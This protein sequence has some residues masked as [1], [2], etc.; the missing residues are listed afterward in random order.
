MK[1]ML[2]FVGMCC[3]GAALVFGDI[4]GVQ[5]TEK[6]M[7]L[8]KPR[9]MRSALFKLVKKIEGDTD[10]LLSMEAKISSRAESFLVENGLGTGDGRLPVSGVG[11]VNELLPV[12]FMET[13]VLMNGSK[14]N[15]DLIQVL[16]SFCYYI[17]R[18][19]ISLD[20][21]SALHPDIFVGI[22]GPSWGNHELMKVCQSV[23][24]AAENGVG[25]H[26][27][28]I[29]SINTDF[30]L[31]LYLRDLIFTDPAK[32]NAAIMAW[33]EENRLNGWHWQW[34]WHLKWKSFLELPAFNVLEIIEPLRSSLAGD[35]SICGEPKG[36][37]RSVTSLVEFLNFGG[38]RFDWG[39]QSFLNSPRYF[40]DSLESCWGNPELMENARGLLAD[41][42]QKA[43]GLTRF[44]EERNDVF[45][46]IKYF[47]PLILEN[48]D[49]YGSA[50]SAWTEENC[51]KDLHWRLKWES[52]LVLPSFNEP[53]IIEPLRDFLRRI[54]TGERIDESLR[55]K[56]LN[57][58]NNVT[59][60]VKF[61]GYL[62]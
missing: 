57:E 36:A 59:S 54:Y 25:S 33:I 28:I 22:L 60:L 40:V 10:H 61:L 29:D 16:L 27:A 43:C 7:E 55:A 2:R 26:S 42:E 37:E 20:H 38:H 48:P 14:L 41:A 30:H 46:L 47:W 3:F 44:R 19:L 6:Q 1:K 5:Q 56:R 11:E 53:K 51:S 15:G 31:T 34:Q 24:V 50:I 23:M 21:R 62:P 12:V 4:C 13:R 45:H 18:G 9:V 39:R 49:E 52:F 58:I 17:S 8:L 35:G 32:F